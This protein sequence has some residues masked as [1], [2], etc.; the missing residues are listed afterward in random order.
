MMG[1]NC[2]SDYAIR[3]EEEIAKWEPLQ[4][5]QDVAIREFSLQEMLLVERIF[6]IR[7]KS[8]CRQTFWV[9]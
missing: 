7:T 1:K 5:I 6:K 9:G 8:Y 2:K 4:D 3:G